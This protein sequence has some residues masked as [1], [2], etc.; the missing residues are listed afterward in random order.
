MWKISPELNIS[1]LKQDY[2]FASFGDSKIEESRF[3]V[4]SDSFSGTTG[5]KTR[6]VPSQ[7][8]GLNLIWTVEDTLISHNLSHVFC[9]FCVNIYN[10][11]HTSNHQNCYLFVRHLSTKIIHCCK[12]YQNN[13]WPN[14]INRMLTK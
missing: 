2:R 6:W 12:C 8:F 14:F 7:K 9:S 10:F 11:L 5:S 4:I 3:P 13:D 1:N